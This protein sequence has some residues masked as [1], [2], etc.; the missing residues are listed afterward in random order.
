MKLSKWYFENPSIITI[1]YKYLIQVLFLKSY[2][3]SQFTKKE[4]KLKILMKL[5]SLKKNK[6]LWKYNQCRINS[7]FSSFLMIMDIKEFSLLEW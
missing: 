5:N 2:L 7:I 6:K 4:K 1:T 3:L